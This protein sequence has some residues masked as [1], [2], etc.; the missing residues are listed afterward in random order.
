MGDKD[1]DV[2]TGEMLPEVITPASAPMK[3]EQMANMMGYMEEFIQKLLKEKVDFGLIPGTTK[4]TLYKAGA[5][6]LCMAFGLS[7]EYK[8]IVSERDS[9]KEWKYTVSY[10]DKK[11]KRQVTETKMAHGYYY[12]SVRCKLIHKGTGIVWASQIGDCEST[13]RGRETAPSNTI[14]KMAQK[15]AFVGATLHATFTSDRFTAD[16]D[17]YEK[18]ESGAAPK[19]KPKGKTTTASGEVP[20]PSASAS[21][22][23][24]TPE[25]KSKCNFCGK[26]HTVIGNPIVQHPGPGDLKGKWGHADCYAGLFREAEPD[27]KPDDKTRP[28]PG[29]STREALLK[30]IPELERECATLYEDFKPL[31]ARDVIVG[32]RDLTKGVDDKLVEYKGT[33]NGKIE[34]ANA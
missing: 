23:Y 13:E 15:R 7:E 3:L 20:A 29:D 21:S 34:E 10:Y 27:P 14:L 28:E 8:I 6:K 32:T 1:L 22:K 31:E 2:E 11:Q 4:P 26:Y 25:K 16:M 17:T 33:L 5:E 12:F 30:E 19:G 9:F 24:G 18:Q